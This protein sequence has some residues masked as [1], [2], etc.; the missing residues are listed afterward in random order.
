MSENNAENEWMSMVKTAFFAVLLAMTIRSVLF[1]PFNIPS[2]SMKPN[3]VIGDY[4]FVSKY[5]Y[6]YSRYSFPFGIA[7]I[8]GRLWE[9]EPKRGDVAVFKLPSDT[10]INYIMSK[11]DW[12][13]VTVYQFQQLEQLKTDDNFEAIVKVVA[14]LFNLTEKQ[15]N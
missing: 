1:E 6:G 3:F 2:E 13:S 11:M 15:V 7:P 14:I 5:T 10:R 8:E 9:S 12:N 4:L